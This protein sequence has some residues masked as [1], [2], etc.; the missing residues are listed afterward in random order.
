M[1]CCSDCC[2]LKIKTKNL[3]I[4]LL[5]SI[6]IYFTFSF[7]NSFYM[8]SSTDRYKKALILLELYN[9]KIFIYPIYCYESAKDNPI[10]AH[11][12]I[13]GNPGCKINGE[14]YEKQ[15]RTID[16]Q[17]NF[18]ELKEREL[19]L[20]IINIIL[21]GLYFISLLFITIKY[22]S[23]INNSNGERIEH[24]YIR[25]YLI[26]I[27][28]LSFI[29]MTISI[30]MMK[31][32]SD[33]ISTNN[34]IGLYKR[35]EEDDISYCYLI[36]II[37]FIITFVS[38]IICNSFSIL[39]SVSYNKQMEQLQSHA[40]N[41]PNDQVVVMA[42]NNPQITNENQQNKKYNSSE[43]NVIQS[44]RKEIQTNPKGNEN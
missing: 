42:Y 24:K 16:S 44:E 8:M 25:I 11:Y 21:S 4:C 30:L 15:A 26:I 17:T 38:S 41:Q 6:F 27:V 7:V 28:V 3:A 1:G 10:Y 13:A 37:V 29:L 43:P 2:C 32:N 23:K 39:V 14:E 35:N 9:K 5:I 19:A 36:N 34:Q 22:L 40:P 20:N 33:A 18:T 12:F 31:C